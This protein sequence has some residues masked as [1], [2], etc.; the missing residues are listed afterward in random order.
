[1]KSAQLGTSGDRV[2]QQKVVTVTVS[3]TAAAEPTLFNTIK[4]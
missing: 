4:D 1:M 2:S 3:S